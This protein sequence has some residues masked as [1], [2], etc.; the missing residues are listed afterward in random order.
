MPLI[1][2]SESKRNRPACQPEPFRPQVLFRYAVETS[3]GYI[4][5]DRAEELLET[6]PRE[7]SWARKSEK[8]APSGSSNSRKINTLSHA[9]RERNHPSPG[10]TT[11]RK[12][13]ARTNVFA[14]ASPCFVLIQNFTPAPGGPAS[15][16]LL[17][18]KP[19]SRRRIR[20]M[21]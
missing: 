7:R 5:S 10:S 19:W 16:L 20:A 4:E 2:N 21:G 8:T 15:T 1:A 18:R 12:R 17:V 6:T 14:A 11:I 13:R 3:K 9:K